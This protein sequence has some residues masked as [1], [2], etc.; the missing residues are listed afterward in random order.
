VIRN[1]LC[2]IPQNGCLN[3]ELQASGFRRAALTF[4]ETTWHVNSLYSNQVYVFHLTI[5]GRVA[6]LKW[7]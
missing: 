7:N 2:Q 5:G 4:P 3:Q 1:Q 6:I